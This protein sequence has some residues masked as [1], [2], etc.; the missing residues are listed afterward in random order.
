MSEANCG[1]NYARNGCALRLQ[2]IVTWIRDTAEQP[3]ASEMKWD[4]LICCKKRARLG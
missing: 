2:A 3:V 1:N 4:D